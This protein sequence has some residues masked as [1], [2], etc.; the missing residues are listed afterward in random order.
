MSMFPLV[1]FFTCLLAYFF[2][3]LFCYLSNEDGIQL[4]LFEPF[5]YNI[6]CTTTYVMYLHT[7]LQM[8]TYTQMYFLRYCIVENLS[9]IVLHCI[10]LYCIAEN[11]S[12]FC[13]VFLGLSLRFSTSS[14]E[15]GSLVKV[16]F[17]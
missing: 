11:V 2:I 8:F 3:H 17:L 14:A 10:V 7:T 6:H 13:A 16:S 12:Y 1:N 15:K 5:M 9:C 4:V